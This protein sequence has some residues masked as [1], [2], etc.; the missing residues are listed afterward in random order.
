MRW[1]GRLSARG[2][3]AVERLCAVGLPSRRRGRAVFVAE[4]ELAGEGAGQGRTLPPRPALPPRSRARSVCGRLA[5]SCCYRRKD[6][7]FRRAFWSASAALRPQVRRRRRFGAAAPCS[8]GRSFWARLWGRAAERGRARRSTPPKRRRKGRSAGVGSL[9]WRTE[10]RDCTAQAALRARRF[11]TGRRMW[12]RCGCRGVRRSPLR[13]R[14][15]GRGVPGGPLRLFGRVLLAPGRRCAGSRGRGCA[16]GG[17]RPGGRASFRS[18]RR[19]GPARRARRRGIGRAGR[20]GVRLARRL[21][22]RCVPVLP[23]NGPRA[24][25]GGVGRPSLHRLGVRLVPFAR[26]AGTPCDRPGSPGAPVAGLPCAVGGSALGRKGGR[27]GLRGNA[28]VRRPTPACRP[29][30]ARRVHGRVHRRKAAYGAVRVLRAFCALDAG[31]RAVRRLGHGLACA[32]LPPSSALRRRGAGPHRRV[33]HPGHAA[34][35]RDVLAGSAGV[36]DCER[37]GCAPVR[38]GV[39]GWSGGGAGRLGRAGRLRFPADSRL[40]RSRGHGAR[41]VGA[42]LHSARERSGVAA[43]S[44]RARPVGGDGGCAVGCVAGSAQTG[45]RRGLRPVRLRARRL[46]AGAAPACRGRDSDAGRGARRRVSYPQPRGG[47]ARG[48][49][50][51]GGPAAGGARA[52]RG[53]EAGR[54]GGHAWGRRSQRGAWVACG[55]CGGGVRPCCERRALMRLRIVRGSGGGCREIGGRRRRPRAVEGR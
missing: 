33:E 12:R 26:F 52:P 53:C 37:G 6:G 11:R 55:R 8:H 42:R 28:L 15:R 10:A 27:H 13:R 29:Q 1:V 32:P 41:R 40:R 48:H 31:H 25:G 34:V 18:Q 50:Q 4:S 36:A 20:L 51:P 49:G 21:G 5:P 35:G 17:K 19:R 45:A 7:A 44:G 22:R 43:R 47:R 24:C 23:G 39:L 46:R 2:R 38:A 54:R 30:R 14:V 9:R 3:R 16:G